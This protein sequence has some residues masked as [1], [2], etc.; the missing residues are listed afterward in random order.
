MV[1][2]GEQFYKNID[3]DPD[4]A[5]DALAMGA[6]TSI[7]NRA[8][9]PGRGQAVWS[10]SLVN[11]TLAAKA[12]QKSISKNGTFKTEADAKG[13]LLY[14]DPSVV[15]HI[16]LGARDPSTVNERVWGKKLLHI[17]DYI[18]DLPAG[19]IHSNN[20]DAS[21]CGQA[22]NRN[23]EDLKFRPGITKCW[24]CGCIIS[25]LDLNQAAAVAMT[26]PLP[27]VIMF[28]N[29]SKKMAATVLPGTPAE[30]AA[31]EALAKK[32]VSWN[33]P[34]CEH[35]IPCLRA[36]MMIGMFA[37]PV[38][39]NQIRAS[40]PGTKEEQEAY[41][42]NWLNQTTDNYLWS[43]AVCNAGA[44]KSATL[45]IDLNNVG[46]FGVAEE[47]ARKLADKIQKIVKEGRIQPFDANVGCTMAVH[48]QLPD[49]SPSCYIRQTAPD[50][51]QK[52]KYG[53]CPNPNPSECS[54]I[55]SVKEVIDWEANRASAQVNVVWSAFGGNIRAFAEYCL[56]QTQLYVSAENIAYFKK[57]KADLE[58]TPAGGGQ[59]GGT[60]TKEDQEMVAEDII[61]QSKTLYELMQQQVEIVTKMHTKLLETLIN[62]YFD[63]GGDERVGSMT[64]GLQYYVFGDRTNPFLAKTRYRQQIQKIFTQY[65]R[66]SSIVFNDNTKFC[67]A[68]MVQMF[69]DAEMTGIFADGNA[70]RG[71][72]SVAD[73]KYSNV[74]VEVMNT[75]A[76]NRSSPEASA[77]VLTEY[78]SCLVIYNIGVA[79]GWHE[80]LNMPH[81]TNPSFKTFSSGVGFGSE[82]DMTAFLI[83]LFATLVAAVIDGGGT[84]VGVVGSTFI[85]VLDEMSKKTYPDRDVFV[86]ELLLGVNNALTA[87][88]NSNVILGTFI[89]QC[90]NMSALIAPATASAPAGA[91]M[92]DQLKAVIGA[93]LLGQVHAQEGTQLSAMVNEG[94]KELMLRAGITT[95]DGA[96]ADA[97]G[98]DLHLQQLQRQQEQQQLQQMQMQQQQL[99]YQQQGRGGGTKICRK[100]RKSRKKR[101]KC[102]NRKVNSKKRGKKKTRGKKQIRRVKRRKVTKRVKRRKIKHSR[103]TR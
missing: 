23:P 69:Q 71:T 91:V 67:D 11:E 21:Q 35:I 39:I 18:E 15:E 30:T 70:L 28:L 48:A 8:W 73:M 51:W 52:T 42:Q 77:R 25:N 12:I 103:K 89:K 41:W 44:G 88:L 75:L 53:N 59:R 83:Q 6:R 93:H 57:R 22:S 101:Y 74:F 9:A 43:H 36:A 78:I 92:D 100:T 56:L 26:V 2:Y 86:Q 5:V 79:Y 4:S 47:K 60:G 54:D 84:E 17:R 55:G 62:P 66:N 14:D 50:Q 98:M 49:N 64:G 80:L 96:T 46:T 45:L 63:F 99:Q 95:P 24:L 87:L 37:K 72:P 94:K 40:I 90:P 81:P 20:P 65:C 3:D 68:T 1:D 13:F 34:Q 7:A 10:P 61:Q 29:M 102:S 27:T 76:R 58:N 33:K 85:A 82:A 97:P 38:V 19:M 16:I 31:R 32:I